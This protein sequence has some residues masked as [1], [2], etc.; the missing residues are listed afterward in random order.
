MR[1]R[2]WKRVFEKQ[3]EIVIREFAITKQAYHKKLFF[4]ASLFDESNEKE[5][6]AARRWAF[7]SKDHAINNWK[8]LPK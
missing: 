3:E 1:R 6:K 8:R 2:G 4:I 7:L 5:K